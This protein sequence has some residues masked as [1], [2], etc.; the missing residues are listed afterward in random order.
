MYCSQH[1]GSWFEYGVSKSAIKA[2]VCTHI[3]K[4]VPE[5]AAF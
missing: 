3:F 1:S 4:A 5:A 2:Q